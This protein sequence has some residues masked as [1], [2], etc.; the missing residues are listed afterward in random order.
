MKSFTKKLLICLFFLSLLTSKAQQDTLL[1][2]F[3]NKNDIALRSVQKYTIKL[4]DIGNEKQ[5]KELLKYQIAC[6]KL[7][8]TDTEKS[9]IMA[10]FVRERCANY[11]LKNTNDYTAYLKLSVSESIYFSTKNAIIQINSYLNKTEEKA[12]NALD[13]KDPHLFNNFIIRIK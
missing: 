8:I 2:I 11:I 4:N 1:K 13:I 5:F 9:A 10:Y 6:V 12:I 3:I 7:Y